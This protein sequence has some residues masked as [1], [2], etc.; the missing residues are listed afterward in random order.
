MAQASRSC[1]RMR[2]ILPS[3][4]P[5]RPHR[6][7]ASAAARRSS[8]SVALLATPS[9]CSRCRLA[10][11][12]RAV[13][14]ESS[15]SVLLPEDWASWATY[16]NRSGEVHQDRWVRTMFNGTHNSHIGVKFGLS[17]EAQGAQQ[18]RTD[19]LQLGCSRI[20]GVLPPAVLP[21]RCL[22]GI[23]ANL[24]YIGEFELCAIGIASL[25]GV[26]VAEGR[27]VPQP[28]RPSS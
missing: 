11:G 3:R 20:E 13:D 12:G 2:A 22:R 25:L 19:L 7:F 15:E 4:P 21:L 10:A 6:S 17:S 9:R 5:K 18:L 26:G 28:R 14:V 27:G 23:D 16:A 24:R 1:A 8:S